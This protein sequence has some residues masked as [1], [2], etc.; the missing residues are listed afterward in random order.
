MIQFNLL[1]DIKVEYLRANRQKHIVVLVS[2]ITALASLAVLAGL[3][4]TVFV[5]QKKSISD[6][7]ADIKKASS[8]LQS[9]PELTK[10]LTVQNQLKALTELHNDKPVATRLFSYLEQSTPANAVN[11]RVL[12]DFTQ[13]TMILTG[14]SD[15]L[16]TVNTYID[17]LKGTTYHTDQDTETEVRAFSNVVLA[18]FG[19]DTQ[20]ASYSITLTFD[21]I[22]FSEVDEVVFSISAVPKN[23]AGQ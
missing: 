18:S 20:S 12:V 6:L 21:P 5:F 23:G 15:S 9:T 13:N 3:V 8:E 10:I 14:I 4:L 22:I 16:S 19:R 7:S 17:S 2:V 11:S 1:P